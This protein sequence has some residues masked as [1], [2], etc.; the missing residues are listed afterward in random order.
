MTED[1]RFIIQLC[2]LLHYY[3]LRLGVDE[4]LDALRAVDQGI[5]VGSLKRTIRILWCRTP[6]QEKVF[7]QVW[8]IIERETMKARPVLAAS[9]RPTEPPLLPASTT[10]TPS[11]SHAPIQE[12]SQQ[13]AA[14]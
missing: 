10:Q 13:V 3:G 5:V 2:H 12:L 11:K 7:D 6:A 1:H 9:P 4:L 8:A 14:T